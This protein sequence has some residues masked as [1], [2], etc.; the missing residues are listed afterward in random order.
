MTIKKLTE[1]TQEGRLIPSNQKLDADL[2]EI[3]S[4][5][6]NSLVLKEDGLYIK[7][8][9]GSGSSFGIWN[10]E[11]SSIL[12]PLLRSFSEI[13]YTNGNL[14]QEA[15]GSYP[16]VLYS[17]CVGVIDG[18]DFITGRTAEAS[19][20]SWVLDTGWHTFNESTLKDSILKLKLTDRVFTFSLSDS[21][22]YVEDS[23]GTYS[24]DIRSILENVSFRVVGQELQILTISASFAIPLSIFETTVT[25]D[26]IYNGSGIPFTAFSILKGSYI[27]Q[28]I[29]TY[30]MNGPMQITARDPIP[31]DCYVEVIVSKNSNYSSSFTNSGLDQVEFCFMKSEGEYL[32]YALTPGEN[33]QASSITS[34]I[35]SGGYTITASPTSATDQSGTVNLSYDIGGESTPTYLHLNI[36]NFSGIPWRLVSNISIGESLDAELPEDAARGNIYSI[37]NSGTVKGEVLKDNDLVIFTDESTF[38][39]ILSKVEIDVDPRLAQFANSIQTHTT[40]LNTLANDIVV[41]GGIA[42]TTNNTVSTLKVKV[43]NLNFYR[44]MYYSIYNIF[45]IPNAKEGHYA[46]LVHLDGNSPPDFYYYVDNNWYKQSMQID[47]TLALT[48]FEKMSTNYLIEGNN[49]YYTEARVRSVINSMIDIPSVTQQVTD[50]QTWKNSSISNM[51]TDVSRGVFVKDGVVTYKN[52]SRNVAESTVDFSVYQ[53]IIPDKGPLQLG[54]TDNSIIT[55]DVPEDLEGLPYWVCNFGYLLTS[56]VKMKIEY[57]GKDNI[58]I[59]TVSTSSGDNYNISSGGVS[60]YDVSLPNRS[61]ITVVEGNLYIGNKKITINGGNN[62]YSYVRK[63]KITRVSGDTTLDLNKFLFKNISLVSI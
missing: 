13:P 54:G 6:G 31:E 35:T 49:L 1:V 19:A 9:E 47:Y 61:K 12:P 39:K 10:V 20:V 40:Q 11:S 17:N 14:V 30:I 53:G 8:G 37:I 43:D 59:L 44:G 25:V 51:L 32:F 62:L 58:N 52:L 33:P 63:I 45:S 24:F 48:V 56:G 41:I 15:R 7:A 36:L 16:S 26:L 2:I 5:S 23:E 42:D 38:K 28:N 18:T 29:S 3:S 21:V 57:L 4:A 46:L 60:L 55:L 22:I 34:R 27:S 50:L